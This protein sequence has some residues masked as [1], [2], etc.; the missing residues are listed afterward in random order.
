MT[1]PHPPLDDA[2]HW[3]TR[4]M[5]A[6]DDQARSEIVREAIN[7]GVSITVI[8]DWLDFVEFVA[9]QALAKA[10]ANKKA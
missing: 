7:A 1:S 5:A 6:A 10:R 8:R 2:D 4:L 9:Q 3:R